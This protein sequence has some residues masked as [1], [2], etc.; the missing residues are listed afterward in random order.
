MSKSAAEQIEE[1]RR[2][3]HRTVKGVTSDLERYG[4]NVAIAKL[5]VLTNEIHRTL[6]SGEAARDAAEL[7]TLMLAPLGPFLAEELW[8]VAL[9]HDTSVHVAPW[10]SFDPVLARED[11][12]VLVVQV[13]GKVRDKFDVS[14]DIS[15]SDAESLALGS[16]RVS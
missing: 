8:R 3:I 14:P 7:L 10:P 9:G 15:E 12:V 4:F 5:M 16:E 11:H 2:L 1:L 6:A 13:D